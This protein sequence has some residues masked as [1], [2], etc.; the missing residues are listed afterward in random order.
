MQESILIDF[1]TAIDEFGIKNSLSCQREGDR[2]WHR[3]ANGTICRDSDLFIAI[4]RM[5]KHQSEER[6]ENNIF[7]LWIYWFQWNWQWITTFEMLL[8]CIFLSLYFLSHEIDGKNFS[9]RFI[10]KSLSLIY[11][12]IGWK[13]GNIFFTIGL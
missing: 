5:Y 6:R 4:N 9:I 11:I 3:A 7:E 13:N 8:I 1:N 10:V 2:E 12:K